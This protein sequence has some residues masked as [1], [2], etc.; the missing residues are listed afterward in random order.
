MPTLPWQLVS[1]AL[2]ELYGLAYLDTVDH[3]SDYYELEISILQ[4][5]KQHFGCH[6]VPHALIMD[7]GAQFIS[8]TF[9]VFEKKYRFQHITSFPYWSQSNGR[10][11]AA[12]KS[13]KHLL[14]A[15]DVDLA[16]LSVCNTPPAGHT[17]SP[18]QRLFGCT[19][20]SNLPQTVTTLQPCTPP[21]DTVVA[22]HAHRKSEQK[23]AYDKHAGPPLPELP[24]GIQVY[25]KLPL[26][27]STKAWIPG[28][29]VGPAGPRSYFVRTGAS[30]IRRNRAQVQLA[31]PRITDLVLSHLNAASDLP[32]KL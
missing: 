29:I 9:K 6:G 21:C 8:D 17:F 10:A 32:D 1:Q 4:A 18:A 26:T 13:A 5:T 15:E 16:L 25:A 31:P 28:E 7:N 20:R 14:T 11:E 12:V 23:R 22:E 3:Y 30:Q 2:F 27:S 24:S 19:L